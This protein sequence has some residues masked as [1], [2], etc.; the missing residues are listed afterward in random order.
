MKKNKIL[1]LEIALNDSKLKIK[2]LENHIKNLQQYKERCQ[3]LE[4]NQAKLIEN[5][6]SKICRC[7]GEKVPNK[8]TQTGKICLDCA[9]C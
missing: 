6:S 1:E 7:Y 2:E 4:K 3:K 8:S 5:H 9:G